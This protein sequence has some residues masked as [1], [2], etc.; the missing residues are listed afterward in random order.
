MRY[1]RLL[2]MR[3]G[4]FR[5]DCVNRELDTVPELEIVFFLLFLHRVLIVINGTRR[6]FIVCFVLNTLLVYMRL[7]RSSIFWRLFCSPHCLC[8]D[9]EWF[10]ILRVSWEGK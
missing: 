2:K 9:Y 6:N 5:F 4:P 8:L 3:M 1:F 7:L 10:R